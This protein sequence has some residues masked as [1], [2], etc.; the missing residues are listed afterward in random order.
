MPFWKLNSNL[1]NAWLGL[2]LSF[3]V[4]EP[5][6]FILGTRRTSVDT[7]RN[8]FTLALDFVLILRRIYLKRVF[9]RMD[10]VTQNDLNTC[11]VIM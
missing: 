5:N 11:E 3:L 9:G 1:L 2:L 6:Q 8:T 4:F 10:G 7:F